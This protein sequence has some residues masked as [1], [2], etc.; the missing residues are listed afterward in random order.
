MH[1]RLADPSCT[2][3]TDPRA[4]PRADPRM[5]KALAPFGLDGHMPVAP[6]R[7]DAPLPDRLAA[8]AATENRM[9][10][11]LEE[12]AHNIPV[13]TGIATMTTT[14]TGVD[15]ND[16]ALYITHPIPAGGELP[17]VVHFHGGGMAINSVTDLSYT[18][19]RETWP[20][21]ALSSSA[22]SSA[23]RAAGSGRIRIR[24]GS[25]TVRRRSDGRTRT[26]RISASAT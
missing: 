16:I 22:S 18:R 26:A 8:V 13:A 10:A 17:G 7:P 2:I 19:A 12:L 14:I 15:G 20:P 4:D 21:Q 24:R 6:V 5:V 25:T 3:G 23:T 9:G 11:V 1:G